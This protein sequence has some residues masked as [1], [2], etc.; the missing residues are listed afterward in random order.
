[1]FSDFCSLDSARRIERQFSG[2]VAG[3]PGELPFARVMEEIRD[4]AVLTAAR[5][6]QSREAVI[7]AAR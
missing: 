1:M 4:C 3:T 5:G 7:A 2:R 6:K